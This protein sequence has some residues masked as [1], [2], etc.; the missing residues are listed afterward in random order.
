[1]LAWAKLLLVAILAFS[2]LIECFDKWEQPWSG[3]PKGE[4]VFSLISCALVIGYACVRRF[5]PSLFR[6]ISKWIVDR[7]SATSFPVIL[8]PPRAASYGSDLSPPCSL[9]LRI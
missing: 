7:Y 5:F 2:P 6:L 1:M 9:P 8:A 3:E 4:F